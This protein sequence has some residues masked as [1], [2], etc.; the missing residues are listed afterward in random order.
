MDINSFERFLVNDVKTIAELEN[1][2]EAEGAIFTTLAQDERIRKKSLKWI[3]N[4]LSSFSLG[5]ISVSPHLRSENETAIEELECWL[6]KYYDAIKILGNSLEETDTLERITIKNIDQGILA[7]GFR[8]VGE[9]NNRF[10][11]DL[12]QLAKCFNINSFLFIQPTGY[13]WHYEHPFFVWNSVSEQIK[14]VRTYK[15]KVVDLID[16]KSMIVN[17][18]R[19]E[20]EPHTIWQ[21][22]EIPTERDYQ[23]K[24][25]RVNLSLFGLTQMDKA[26]KRLNAKLR[27]KDLK[28]FRNFDGKFEEYALEFTQQEH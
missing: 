21:D 5:L 12:A 13:T 18:M 26:A 15:G 17:Q 2:V 24:T 3:L 22:Y 8:K 7:A 11:F 6:V 28:T 23:I 4:H 9:E 25:Q 20:R 10:V 14:H 1:Q 16:L 27:S 19:L